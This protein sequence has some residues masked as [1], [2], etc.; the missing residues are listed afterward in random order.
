MCRTNQHWLSCVRTAELGKR[1]HVCQE[2]FPPRYTRRIMNA[3]RSTLRYLVIVLVVFLLTRVVA[4]VAA[5]LTHPPGTSLLHS[6]TQ[7]WDPFWYQDIAANGYDGASELSPGLRVACTDVPH[8]GC[9]PGSHD[10]HSNLAFF[11]LFPV[12]IRTLT[13]LGLDPLVAGLL[14]AWCA[15]AIAAI[16]IALIAR[17]VAGPR[18]GLIVVVLWSAMP[19]NIVLSSGRPE[20]LFIALTSACL[21]LLLRGKLIPAAVLAALAGLSRLQALA[22]VLPVIMA[23]WLRPNTWLSRVAATVI[24]PLGVLAWLGLVAFRTGNLSGWFDIQ[25]EWVSFNDWGASKAQFI[26]EHLFDGPLNY[27]VAAWTIVIACGLW[28]VCWITRV[29]WQ[30]NVY[31]GVLLA[32]VVG[33]TFMH[34][35]SMRYLLAAFPL[36]IP[37]GQYMKRWPT[38]VT[39]LT[40]ALLTLL[41]ASFQYWLWQLDF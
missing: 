29:P 37:I 17:D 39:V 10:R 40:L 21:L 25:R 36:L 35:Q 27:S 11:P 8:A 41:S 3:R 18:A 23:A 5:A 1:E 6:L 33:Q 26:A 14:L 16:L 2:A 31:S 30:L 9:L 7:L 12:M 15:A 13:Y 24:A 28:V 32:A 34:L 4:I 20:P 22:V 38:A 19:A